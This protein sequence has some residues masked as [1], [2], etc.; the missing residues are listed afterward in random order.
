M[1]VN[2]IDTALIHPTYYLGGGLS[3]VAGAT[4]AKEEES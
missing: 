1:T 4:G 2:D 3:R